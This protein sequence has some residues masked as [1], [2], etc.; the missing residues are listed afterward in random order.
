MHLYILRRLQHVYETICRNGYHRAGANIILHQ[1][2]HHLNTP[3]DTKSE[4]KSLRFSENREIC[5]QLLLAD[6]VVSSE[7]CRYM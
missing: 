4:N 7:I 1:I 5:Q 2:N 3:P 6:M